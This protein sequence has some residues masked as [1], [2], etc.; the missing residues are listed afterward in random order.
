MVITD[1][2][3]GLAQEFEK[4]FAQP[5]TKTNYPPFNIIEVDKDEWILEYAVAGL[6]KEHLEITTHNGV[7]TIKNVN[8]KED[9]PKYLHKGIADR[10]FTHSITMPKYSEVLKAET[11]DGILSITIVR[12]IPEELQP[13]VVE[14]QQYNNSKVVFPLDAT[15][16]SPEHDTKLLIYYAIIFL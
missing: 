4:I 3:A 16:G 5:I 2:F 13:K 8:E 1:P 14:I 10:K 12:A 7:L 11:R 6:N 9:T 15:L